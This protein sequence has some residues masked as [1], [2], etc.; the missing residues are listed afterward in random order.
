MDKVIVLDSSLPELQNN[1]SHSK[2]K[3]TCL[4]FES[5]FLAYLLESMRNTIAE[6]GIFGKSH[7]SKIFRSMF[8][9]NLALG[10]ARGGGIGLGAMLFEQ[11]KG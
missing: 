4:E 5:I 8:D 9:E 1:A 2:L 10:I 7:E 6:D 11:L 3:R